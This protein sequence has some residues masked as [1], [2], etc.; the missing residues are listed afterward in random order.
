M[1]IFFKTG[2]FAWTGIIGFWIPAA[3]FGVWYIVMTV[4][5]LRAIRDEAE[6]DLGSVSVTDRPS[7]A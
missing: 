6:L 2:P 5:L 1:I 4:Y 3:V 7:A